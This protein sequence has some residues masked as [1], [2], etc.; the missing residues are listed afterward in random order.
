[1]QQDTRVNKTLNELRSTLDTQMLCLLISSYTDDN[2]AD[3]FLNLTA[4]QATELII[5]N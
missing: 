5:C 3:E 2:I 1:M 4:N